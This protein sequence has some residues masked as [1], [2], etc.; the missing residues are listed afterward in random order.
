RPAIQPP[1]LAKQDHFIVQEIAYHMGAN[2]N[3]ESAEDIWEEIRRLAPNFAGVTYDRLD[4]D[5][6]LQWPCP[7]VSHPGTTFIHGRLWEEKVEQKAPFKPVINRDPVE[8]PDEEYPLQ[9]T[10]GRRLEFYN[11]GVQTSNYK[12]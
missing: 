12:K 2:L 9:L 10:T 3:Y 5:G 11:T 6:G 7:D 1:G 8:L 4:Q